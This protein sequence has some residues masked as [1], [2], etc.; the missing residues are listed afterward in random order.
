MS[1]A[2]VTAQLGR[3]GLRALWVTAEGIRKNKKNGSTLAW[4]RSTVLNL[5]PAWA[6]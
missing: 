5:R 4:G 1:A 3:Y 2:P 6:T